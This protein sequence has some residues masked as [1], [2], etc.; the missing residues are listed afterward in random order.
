ME[1]SSVANM[2]QSGASAAG[3]GGIFKVIHDL[4]TLY[5]G[6]S[7]APVYYVRQAE[8]FF[9][10]TVGGLCCLYQTLS[11]PSAALLAMSYSG[12]PIPL[13]EGI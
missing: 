4:R 12:S 6:N 10:S 1:R 11:R 3:L 5:L 2:F 13:H 8:A 7:E 9:M